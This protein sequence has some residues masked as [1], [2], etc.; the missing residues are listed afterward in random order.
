M[1][2][3]MLVLLQAFLASVSSPRFFL[4]VF[5]HCVLT[6]ATTLG[7]PEGVSM[8]QVFMEGQLIGDNGRLCS[9]ECVSCVEYVV[10]S[11]L[12]RE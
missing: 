7:R 8:P 11:Q 10:D 6:E 9:R 2:Q 3:L 4:T 1:M 5:C 12:R